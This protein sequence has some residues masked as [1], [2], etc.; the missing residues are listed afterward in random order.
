MADPSRDMRSKEVDSENVSGIF[1]MNT[2]ATITILYC[3]Y[4]KD[5]A[6]QIS[7]SIRKLQIFRKHLLFRNCGSKPYLWIMDYRCDV[8][9]RSTL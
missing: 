1:S 4:Y 9:L 6:S 3:T 2:I 7:F 5:T 8:F